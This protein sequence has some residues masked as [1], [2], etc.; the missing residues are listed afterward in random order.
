MTAPARTRTRTRTRAQQVRTRTKPAQSTVEA[1]EEPETRAPRRAQPRGR[2]S[3][4]ERAYARRAQRTEELRAAEA[5]TGGRRRFRLLRLVKLR[6]PRSRAS[7]VLVMMGLLAAGVAT[8]LWLSTQAI[9]DTYRLKELRQAN[10]DLSERAEQLQREVTMRE[11]PSWL[12][13]QARQLGMVPGGD[14]ARLVVDREGETTLVGEPEKVTTPAPPPPATPPAESEPDAGNQDGAN[15]DDADQDDADQDDR[16]SAP[17]GE[18]QAG[19]NA[20]P[21]G[22]D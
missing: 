8:T 18:R 4:A 10:A 22:G 1:P 20:A 3:A 5:D 13:E 2:S 21:G 16:D 7:F 19:D 9:A 15:Q 11:S 12:A 6:L 17:G 14:P